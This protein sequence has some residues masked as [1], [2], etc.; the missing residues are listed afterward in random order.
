[1]ESV[2]C[3]LPVDKVLE[4]CQRLDVRVEAPQLIIDCL[5]SFGVLT[6]HL[7]VRLSN[8]HESIGNGMKLLNA[9][10]M[11]RGCCEFCLGCHLCFDGGASGGLCCFEIVLL[12]AFQVLLNLSDAFLLFVQKFY[13]SFTKLVDILRYHAEGILG[14]VLRRRLRLFFFFGSRRSF[15]SIGLGIG[16]RIGLGIGRCWWFAIYLR[17]VAIE[18]F[19]RAIAEFLR[20]FRHPTCGAEDYVD[21]MITVDRFF[22]FP[23]VNGLIHPLRD[24]LAS[25]ISVVFAPCFEKEL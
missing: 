1:M 16:L 14:H 2:C 19:N 10:S 22:V 17:D 23:H 15:G 20:Q 9:L 6:D 25:E 24:E 5:A 3:H 4:V 8:G 21:L 11:R 18:L 7:L 12:V 13:A